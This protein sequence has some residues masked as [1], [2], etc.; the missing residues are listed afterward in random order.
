LA[1]GWNASQIPG[2]TGQVALITGAN[3]G[4]GLAAAEELAAH[5]A[6]VLLACRDPDRGE[7]ALAAVRAR[8]PAGAAVELIALDLADLTSVRTATTKVAARPGPLDL[9]VANAGVMA[10]PRRETADGFELQLGSNHL[11]HFALAGLLAEKLKSAPAPRVV[12]VT[13]GAHRFG[14]IDFDDLQRRHRYRRWSAYGQSKLANLLFALELQRRA[15]AADLDLLS[16]AAHPGYAATNLQHA[17][18]QLD[19]GLISKLTAPAWS[20]SNHLLGQS[21]ADGALPTLYAATEPDLP[22]GSLIGPGGFASMRGA[23]T[24]EAPGGGALDEGTA[25]R[26]WEVSEQLTGVKFTL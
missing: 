19:A 12:T 23:P 7:A 1:I 10:P 6:S 5:G 8:R 4:I 2:L 11:G 3:S 17:G 26:L 16:M 18:P 14:K 13:S 25:R 24:L 21:A 15:A 9:L 22:G 20:I